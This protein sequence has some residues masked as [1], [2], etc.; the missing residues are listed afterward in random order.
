MDYYGLG[1]GRIHDEN[2]VLN[3]LEK[4]R[5]FVERRPCGVATIG[6]AVCVYQIH[7]LA[8]QL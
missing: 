1:I 5:E 8:P 7:G 2:S 3:R 6:G 4:V